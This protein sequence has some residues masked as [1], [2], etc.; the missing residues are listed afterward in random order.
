MG[1]R[2]ETRRKSVVVVG[3]AQMVIIVAQVIEQLNNC[4]GNV[5]ANGGR[6]GGG[7]SE[8]AD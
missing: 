4:G 1:G 7:E 8:A 3:L 6:S 5:R 2:T